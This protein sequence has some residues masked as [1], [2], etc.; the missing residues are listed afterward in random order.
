MSTHEAA[1]AYLTIAPEYSKSLGGLQ[2]AYRYD[3]IEWEDGTTLALS[4]EL[5]SFLEGLFSRLTG[6]PF[7][8]A[9]HIFQLMKGETPLLVQ[10]EFGRLNRAFESAKGSVNLARNAGVLT[11]ELCVDLPRAAAAPDWASIVSA[12]ERRRTQGSRHRPGLAEEPPLSPAE[13]SWRIA[14]RLRQWTDESLLHWLKFGSGPSTAGPKLADP[15]DRLA[16]RI[17]QLQSLARSRPRLAGA[18]ALAPLVDAA[19]TLP[20]RRRPPDSLPQGGYHD[21]TTRGEP[22]RL[23]PGQF[24]LDPDEF[25]RRFASHELLYFKREE[26]HAPDR[27]RRW[28]VL[29]QGVRTWGTV[30]LGLAAATFA[31]LAKDPKRAG[32]V[33]L[34]LTSSSDCDLLTTDLEQLA[35]RLEASD[36][37]PRPFECLSRVVEDASKIAEPRDVILLTHTRTAAEPDLARLAH[38]LRPIDRLFSLSV[39]ESG[40]AELAEWTARGPKLIRKFRVDLSVAE[41][42]QVKSKTP[43]MRISTH[44]GAWSG[45]VEPIPFPFRPGILSELVVGGFDASGDWA[46]VCGREGM[47][48]LIEDGVDGAPEVL[49]R[50]FR[51]HQ[52]LRN[53]DAVLGVMGGVVVCGRIP[54]PKPMP[55]STVTFTSLMAGTPA[56]FASGTDPDLCFAVAHYDIGARTVRL[57]VLD[58][59]A[60]IGRWFAYPD[61]HCVVVQHGAAPHGISVDLATG[62][63]VAHD[64]PRVSESSR[65]VIAWKRATLGESAT[66]KLRIATTWTDPRVPS[67]TLILLGNSIEVRGVDPPWIRFEPTDEGKPRLG[68]V[69]IRDA[70]LTADILKL[71][72]TRNGRAATLLFR[73]PEGEFIREY[74]RTSSAV[75]SCLSRD[76]RRLLHGI[77]SRAARIGEIGGI[78]RTTVSQSKLHSN[79]E[80]RLYDPFALVFRVGN[81]EHTFRVVDGKLTREQGAAGTSGRIRENRLGAWLP[82]DSARFPVRQTFRCGGVLAV[83]DRLGQA[84][85][86]TENALDLVACFVVRRYEAA[87]WLPDGTVW[88][89]PSILG[90]EATPDAETLI[91]RAILNAIGGHR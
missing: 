41:A 83:L 2:W 64:G 46:V 17:K 71:D 66:R 10:D 78:A 12:L 51:D 11:G 18:L 81:W 60:A 50:A 72:V 8:F 39:D 87:A 62:A 32:P 37:S 61:L 3:A 29:D 73:G 82:Y 30:R 42:A 16:A 23:L 85:L 6:T 65:A 88:G 80:L 74:S 86:L 22:E 76:G 75:L 54:S 40:R 27:P 28:I 49:P 43:Q 35:D 4:E 89:C 47:P 44:F 77:G 67:P 70:E 53:V 14:D 1:D 45:D 58:S 15:L 38:K 59:A 36:L 48:H 7:V 9:L 13:F 34:A 84:V 21:V 52:V 90:R 63:M 25:V 69:S 26:P 79:S 24:A 33:H 20:P 19:L 31:L 68:G 91:G 55:G 56:A 5:T 57:H